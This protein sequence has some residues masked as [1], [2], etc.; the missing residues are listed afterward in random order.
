[1]A[2]LETFIAGFSP[3]SEGGVVNLFVAAYSILDEA[4]PDLR[5]CVLSYL[6]ALVLSLGGDDRAT[7]EVALAELGIGR[8]DVEALGF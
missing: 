7:L 1:M 8:P 5:H 2:D 6:A 4:L 3:G